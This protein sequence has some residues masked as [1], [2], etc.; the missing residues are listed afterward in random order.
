MAKATPLPPEKRND[1]ARQQVRA[2]DI[3]DPVAPQSV[4]EYLREVRLG[5]GQGLGAASRALRT[6]S[7]QLEAIEDSRFDDLPGR[8]Y[9][10]GFIRSYAAWLGLDAAACVGKFKAE[11][12][13]RS[14]HA[15]LRGLPEDTGE[16]RLPYG[17][18]FMAL[19][20]LGVVGFGGYALVRSAEFRSVPQ[21]IA[22]VPAVIAPESGRHASAPKRA[23]QPQQTNL[24]AHAAAGPAAPA[25]LAAAAGGAFNSAA[26]TSSPAGSPFA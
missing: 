14:E 4:G 24:A 2:G 25:G 1:F 18:L 19:V 16:S 15:P 13:G 9:A 10:V 8:T 5:R 22:P 17:W 7:D 26:P 6:R 20:V 23:V 12:A 3:P 21:S 11:T